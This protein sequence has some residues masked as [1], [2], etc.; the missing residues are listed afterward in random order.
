V[1]STL[2]TAKQAVYY[3][4]LTLSAAK[5]YYANSL[6]G[7]YRATKKSPISDRRYLAQKAEKSG[8]TSA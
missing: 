7:R 1:F 8:V 2:Q 5:I 3:G 6:L 4:F